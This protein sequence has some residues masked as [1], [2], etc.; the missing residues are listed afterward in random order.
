MEKY[1]DLYGQNP[2]MAGYITID[3]IKLKSPVL[4]KA[5]GKNPYAEASQ[6]GAKT[7]N[8]VVY[9]NDDSL[10]KYYSSIDAY[11]HSASGFVSYSDL[12]QD[13]N[14]KIIG[15]FYINTKESDDNGYIFPYNVTE[16]QTPSSSLEFFERLH[17]RFIYNTDVSPTRDD[18]LITISCPT[19]Y[20]QDFRFV[21]VGVARDDNNKLKAMPKNLVRY[22]QVICNEKGIANNFLGASKWYPQIVISSNGKKN[23]TTTKII[24]QSI[25]DYK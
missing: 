17:Y 24:K 10:E 12:K 13:Y 16:Q 6:K 21:I 7:T 5:D 11:N 18:T 25:K 9:L 2:N 8:F 20:H 22:P 1:C 15:A 19:S 3:D 23:E 4:V 14:F